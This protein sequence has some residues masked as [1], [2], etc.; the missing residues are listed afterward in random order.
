MAARR[1]AIPDYAYRSRS[2][3]AEQYRP[4][5]P[6]D[7]EL[8]LDFELKELPKLRRIALEIERNFKKLNG[9]GGAIEEINQ[10]ALKWVQNQA[11]QNLDASIERNQRYKKTRSRRLE[12]ALV[13]PRFSKADEKGFS[14]LIQSPELIETVPYY[15]AV[16]KGSRASIGR[17][18]P[19][20][21]LGLKGDDLKSQPRRDTPAASLRYPKRPDPRR[22]NNRRNPKTGRFANQSSGVSR[23]PQTRYKGETIYKT[24][25]S[26]GPSERRRREAAGQLKSPFFDK[27]NAFFIK[28]KRPVPAYHYA[29]RA[30]V[31]FRNQNVWRS[32]MGTKRTEIKQQMTANLTKVR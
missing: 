1:P 27:S 20:L 23:L 25:R 6:L 19:M 17:V 10:A 29:E 24:D 14:F 3:N 18:I 8:K 5:R 15:L 32:I 2:K 16:E 26:I 22:G 11:V 21:F 31:A 12:K 28:V 7:V 30:G 9:K 13:D 4:I